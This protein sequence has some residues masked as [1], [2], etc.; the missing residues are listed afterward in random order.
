MPQ[1]NKQA[2]G[3]KKN[4]DGQR[5][6]KN[7]GKK[8]R[9][10]KNGT[11]SRMREGTAGGARKEADHLP[12]NKAGSGVSKNG[13]AVLSPGKQPVGGGASKAPVAVNVT[14]KGVGNLSPSG[15]K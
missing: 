8:G 13:E 15:N 1:E 3:G 7:E 2:G 4:D 6:V 14:S 12:S 5:I 11:E 10:Q 9:N